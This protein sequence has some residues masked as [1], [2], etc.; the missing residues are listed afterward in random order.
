MPC[1]CK[2]RA[3]LR[4]LFLQARRVQGIAPAHITR[5]LDIQHFGFF[6]LMV[7][8]YFGKGLASHQKGF[9]RTLALHLPI[10]DTLI[11]T[12]IRHSMLQ[13]QPFPEHK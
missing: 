13:L 11:V 4:I 3:E 10:L 12:F 5:Y 6:V 8:S 7:C 2:S 9:A 1:L